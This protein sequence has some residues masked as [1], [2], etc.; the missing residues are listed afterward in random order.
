MECKKC[1][2]HFFINSNLTVTEKGYRAV[3]VFRNSMAKEKTNGR[4]YEQKVYLLSHTEIMLKCK[5]TLL[6]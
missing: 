4:H 6:T 2:I 5:C 1:F 3:S